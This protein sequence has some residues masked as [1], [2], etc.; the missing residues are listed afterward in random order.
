MEKQENL[1]LVRNISGNRQLYIWATSNSQAKRRYCKTFGIQPGDDWCGI[2][3]LRARRLKPEEVRAWE[4][5]A[6]DDARTLQFLKGMMD[7]CSRAFAE[8]EA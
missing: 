8:A 2:P 7:I 6:A 1:Y 3:A 5:Q 4:D